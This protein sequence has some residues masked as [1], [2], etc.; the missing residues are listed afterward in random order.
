MAPEICLFVVFRAVKCG[1]LATGQDV[2]RYL[3]DRPRCCLE[4]RVLGLHPPAADHGRAPQRSSQNDSLADA[5]DDLAVLP[6]SRPP[7]GR[8]VCPR[9][10]LGT[11]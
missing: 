10:L 7:R 2:E 8:T 6:G 4:R 3:H 9:A 5:D 1:T 11:G